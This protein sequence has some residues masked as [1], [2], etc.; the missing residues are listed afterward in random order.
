MLDGAAVVVE[1][2]DEFVAVEAGEFLG[3]G[4]FLLVGLVFA[5]GGEKI[6]YELDGFRGF[7]AGQAVL[8]G[9]GDEGFRGLEEDGAASVHAGVHEVAANGEVGGGIVIDGEHAVFLFGTALDALKGD[10]GGGG[11]GAGFQ[12]GFL[13][14]VRSGGGGAAAVGGGG[15]CS[16]SVPCRSNRERRRVALRRRRR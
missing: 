8:G 4:G 9:A 6:R 5:V 1:K 16:R 14:V 12:S 7:V 11:A 3:A 13:G 10:V 15:R 2:V